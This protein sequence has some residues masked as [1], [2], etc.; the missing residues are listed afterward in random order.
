MW[1]KILKK[2]DK[3]SPPDKIVSKTL[4]PKYQLMYGSSYLII[5]DGSGDGVKQG[6]KILRANLQKGASAI[7]V[8]RTYPDK[9]KKRYKLE[10]VPMLWLSRTEGRT[11]KDKKQSDLDFKVIEPTK[12]GALLEEI[13]EF[14]HK[15]DDTIVIFDGL[16]YLTVHN[17]F[18][19][20]LKFLHGLE[21]E[22]ALH[23]SRLIVAINP[24]ALDD[25]N[26]VLIEKE[27]KILN[28][29]K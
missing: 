1:Y 9:I 8:T 19:R 3:I 25:K 29:G 18:S 22:I 6:F 17:E 13:K 24:K 16:E 11:G 10:N 4:T 5:E 15:M 7:I 20:V 2:R 12:L 23:R 21:D 27:F 14:I 28:V 26:R